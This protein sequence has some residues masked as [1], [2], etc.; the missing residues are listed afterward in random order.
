M[1]KKY[2]Y[3]LNVHNSSATSNSSKSSN[4]KTVDIIDQIKEKSGSIVHQSKNLRS[5]YQRVCIGKEADLKRKEKLYISAL[6]RGSPL[7]ILK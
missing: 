6:N 3:K 1:G 4:S 2:G 7:N 5:K